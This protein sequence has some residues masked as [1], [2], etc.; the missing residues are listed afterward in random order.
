MCFSLRT[1]AIAV[2]D[3]GVDG[4]P[5]FMELPLQTVR[6]NPEVFANFEE[7]LRALSATYKMKE[8]NALIGEMKLDQRNALDLA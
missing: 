7:V 2:V 4:A 8:K 1:A 5:K 3:I 6:T